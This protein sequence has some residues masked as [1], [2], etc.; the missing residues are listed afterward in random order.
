[1]GMQLI[2]RL[3]VVLLL[4]AGRAAAQTT[5]VSGTITD[6]VGNPYANG[7]ASAIQATGLGLPTPFPITVTTNGSGAFSFSGPSALASPASYIFTICAPPTSIGPRANPTPPQ[8]CFKSGPIAISG[9]S[10]DVSAA[11]NAVANTLG[12]NITGVSGVV[13]SG[14]AGQIAV[15]AVTGTAVTGSS[16]AI[17]NSTTGNAATATA[18]ASAPTQCSNALA[19]GI[20]TNGNAN[21]TNSTGTGGLA[22]GGS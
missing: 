13:G 3:L 7:T 17:S 11:L 6:P 10:Q 5:E 22:V 19:T 16:S 21:C 18:L 15:Y 4:G 9:A 2:R 12:P 8:V 20:A 1:M 14:T